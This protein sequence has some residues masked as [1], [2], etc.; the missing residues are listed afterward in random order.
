M[1]AKIAGWLPWALFAIASIAAV[2]T[3]GLDL[4][5]SNQSVTLAYILYNSIWSLFSIVFTFLSA[6]VLSRQPHHTV[7]WLLMIPGIDVALLGPVDGYVNSL[8]SAPAAPGTVLL[9]VIWAQQW[10]WLP[11]IFP[12][13]L[14]PLYFPT[15]QPPSPRWRWVSSLALGMCVF[16]FFAATFSKSLDARNAG[17]AVVNPIGFLPDL[18]AI[19]P[20]WFLSLGILTTA[21]VAALLVRF[22][23]GT[24]VERQQ[25]KWLLYACALFAAFYVTSLFL[26][27][28]IRSGIIWDII[29]ALVIWPIPI[30]IALSILRYRL[31]DI[32]ILIRRTLVYSLLTGLLALL[33]FGSV[34]LLQGIF[35]A[36]GGS[37]STAAT[38]ISTLAIAALSNPLRRRFQN[39]IDQRFYRQKF[40]AELSLQGFAAVARSETEPERLT[41][42]MLEIVQTAIQPE[43]DFIW[44]KSQAVQRPHKWMK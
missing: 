34:T 19:W 24:A 32:D 35:T 22:Q 23:K 25:I 14:I 28:S 21:S 15:G 18:A 43:R 41:K 16:F 17:W 38:V 27:D 30:S 36:L 11:L 12:L 2:V 7:G 3:I 44:L 42:S 8:P 13:L 37:Q 10:I 39:F 1:R 29:F 26:D 6:L 31:W 33:Y 20:F 9:L 4:V 5:G 40:D